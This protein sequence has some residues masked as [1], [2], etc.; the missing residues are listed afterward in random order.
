MQ[1]INKEKIDVIKSLLL[2]RIVEQEIC[3]RYGSV[4]M[5]QEMRCPVHISIGQ[6]SIAVGVCSNLSKTDQIFSGHRSHAHYLAKG[7]SPQK[8]INEI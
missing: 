4:G 7:G 6:E 3:N 5:K 8:M 2:I 1:K